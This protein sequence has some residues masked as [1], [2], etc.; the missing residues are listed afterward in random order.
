MAELEA[1][2]AEVASVA[3]RLNAAKTYLIGDTVVRVRVPGATA[4]PQANPDIPLDAVPALVRDLK[5]DH[6]LSGANTGFWRREN[7]VKEL[8]LMAAAA[9]RIDDLDE[10]DLEA[11]VGLPPDADYHQQGSVRGLLQLIVNAC[12]HRE[13]FPTGVEKDQPLLAK[14]HIGRTWKQL[15]KERVV[16]RRPAL[17]ALIAGLFPPK[18]KAHAT[19]VEDVV[20]LVQAGTDPVWSSTTAPVDIG[21]RDHEHERKQVFVEVRRS[22]V[23]PISEW[24]PYAVR[25]YTFFIEDAGR[26]FH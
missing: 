14:T 16:A 1:T 22:P 15:E 4:Q 23:I 5:G 8:D 19:I 26:R 9:A 17:V 6:D 10:E 12:I 21:R 7:T 2:V 24:L 3:A 25:M 11:A 20:K 13:H 18:G